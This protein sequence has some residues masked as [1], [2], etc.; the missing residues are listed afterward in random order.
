MD[1]NIT[2][3]FNEISILPATDMRKWGE[4]DR[5]GG[6]ENHSNLLVD[7]CYSNTLKRLKIPSQYT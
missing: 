1:I 4:M 7:I 5:F 3:W 6:R 2:V